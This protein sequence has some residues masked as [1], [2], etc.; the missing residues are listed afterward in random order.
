MW[1]SSEE[2]FGT[3]V[4]SHISKQVDNNGDGEKGTRI[5]NYGIQWDIRIVFLYYDQ[6]CVAIANNVFFG[7][8]ILTGLDCSNSN[9]CAPHTFKKKLTNPIPEPTYYKSVLC[10]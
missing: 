2:R 6:F 3:N 9:T 8:V 5:F 1:L 7:V 10:D 4:L